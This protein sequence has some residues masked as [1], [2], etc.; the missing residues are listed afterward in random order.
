[1]TEVIDSDVYYLVFDVFSERDCRRSCFSLFGT[2]R[3]SE[4]NHYSTRKHPSAVV[5]E[6]PPVPIF[7]VA[8]G[9]TCLDALHSFASFRILAAKERVTDVA[10]DWIDYDRDV[11]I[12]RTRFRAE[13]QQ[14]CRP[15]IERFLLTGPRGDLKEAI[16][17]AASIH[18]RSSQRIKGFGGV[19]VRAGVSRRLAG[20]GIYRDFITELVS[21]VVDKVGGVVVEPAPGQRV[22]A[23]T[24]TKQQRLTLIVDRYSELVGSVQ[25]AV[26]ERNE[27]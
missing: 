11:P 13:Q 1:M 23:A 27:R 9:E 17:V 16:E 2:D 20:A 10:P 18:I 8:N 5:G 22:P 6:R 24:G 25:L 12:S 7:T 4:S 14:I 15:D 3:A 21:G 19:V 26:A